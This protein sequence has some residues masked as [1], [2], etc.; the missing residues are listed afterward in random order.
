MHLERMKNDPLKNHRRKVAAAEAALTKARDQMRAAAKR[1]KIPT[2]GLFS[3]SE[4]VL[5]ITADRWADE[6]KHAARWETI[7]TFQRLK[8][9][10][11]NPDSSPF[12]HL[13]RYRGETQAPPEA[14]LETPP[15]GRPTLVV[16]NTTP[17][18][19]QMPDSA[20]VKPKAS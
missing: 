17:A 14:A 7:K 8:E 3:D 6:A 10:I 4:F 18:V 2:G 9:I 5:R 12:S 15:A 20:P 1:A 19:P 11:E 13:A 16:D